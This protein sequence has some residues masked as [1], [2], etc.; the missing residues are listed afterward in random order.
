MPDRN[1]KTISATQVSALF[2]CSP[3]ETRFS[4]YHWFKEPGEW[5]PDQD[6]GDERMEWGRKMQHLILE[7]AADALELEITEN[8]EDEYIRRGDLGATLDA[9]V[10]CPDRGPGALECKAV[11]DFTQWM[12]RWGGGVPPRD[13]ELQLQTQMLVGDGSDTPYQWGIF[14]VWVCGEMHYF[15]RKPSEDLWKQIVGRSA[16]F[17]ASLAE[18][19]EPDPF[20]APVEV[21]IIN[22]MYPA[23]EE[24]KIID[25]DRDDLEEDARMYVYATEQ[26]RFWKKTVDKI[27]PRLMNAARDA[28]T[29]RFPHGTSM[30]VSKS[31]T[32]GGTY[33]RK[34]GLRTTLKVDRPADDATVD[35]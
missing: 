6:P 19:I 33:E 8:E 14:A 3:Y 16:S 25:V 15:E 9:T 32:K 5:T 21:P 12:Q 23:A 24:K 4:L 1:R 28:D 10:Y 26:Q 13:L 17:M 30:Y 35:L 20:G 34:P 27:K 31:Q 22:R 7:T 18:G 11:F 29:V 2:D